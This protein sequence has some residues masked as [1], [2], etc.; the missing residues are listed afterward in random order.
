MRFL[1]P[2]FIETQKTK[3]KSKRKGCTDP[4]YGVKSM[5]FKYSSK[6]KSANHL[7]LIK[8]IPKSN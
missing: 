3:K 8:H 5:R 7:I 6:N 1:D 2:M 4:L